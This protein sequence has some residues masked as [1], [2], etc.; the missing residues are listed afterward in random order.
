[1]IAFTRGVP[2][3]A[4]FPLEQLNQ[5]VQEAMALS[6]EAILPYA[7]SR[8]FAPL[9]EWLAEAQC[10]SPDQA[11]VS[12]GALQILDFIARVLVPV[13]ATVF[14][15]QPSYDRAVTIFHRAGCQV[16]GVPMETDGI[17]L[18]ALAE[19]GTRT[20]P[21]VFYLIPDFQNPSGATL[22]LAKREALVQW[23]QQGGCL[24]VEDIPYRRLRYR[25]EDLPTLRSLWPEGT[26]QLSS[27][28]KLLS[29][30]LRVGTAFGPPEKMNRLA[31]AAEDTY[32]TPSLLNQALVYRFLA[33]GWLDGQ[34]EKLRALY[35]PR[36]EATL[37]S[38]GQEMGELADW[39]RPEGGFFVGLTLKREVRAETLLAKGKEAGLVLTDGRGFFADGSGDRFVRLPFCAL[40]VEEIKS[41]VHALAQ[42]VRGLS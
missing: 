28:S 32:I 6:H 41:G 31:K 35:G 29:P 22:S 40:S 20:S 4:A 13:G 23:A 25:G 7:G 8:G 15:E 14:V 27:F 3:P 38:L 33:N 19:I 24:L 21:V 9:R 11:L 5:C 2:D 26:I 10:G 34:V 18:V 37:E 30:G 17:D 42:V 16:V 36:L 39:V 12:H 1:M